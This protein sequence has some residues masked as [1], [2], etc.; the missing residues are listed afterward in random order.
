ML[1]M[2]ACSSS[3]D[4]DDAVTTDEVV[5]PDDSSSDDSSIS[6]EDSS[7]DSSSSESETTTTTFAKGADVSWLTEMEA[8]GKKF[9][10]SDG[11]ETECMALLQSLG[12]DAI[13]LRVWVDPTDGY[14][15]KEDVLT[16]AKRANA[17]GMRL[18]IDF[19]YSDSW[20]DPEKQ[21]KP[22]AWTNYSLS[23]LKTAITDHTKDVLNAL[24]DEG[25]TPEWVQVGN[26]IGSGIL[27]DT[28]ATVSG[29]TWNATYDGVTYK[30]NQSNFAAFISTGCAAVR[31]VCP[32]AKIVIHLQDA[33]G[34]SGDYM[35]TWI[36]GD[37][38]KTYGT[39]D[40]DV[41]GFSIYPETS[42]WSSKISTYISRMNSVISTYGKEVMVCETGMSW[43]SAS[44]CNSYLTSLLEKTSAIDG[45]L[46]VFYWEPEAYG[47]WNGY[48][49]GAF[50]NSGKPTEALDA[51]K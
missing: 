46:G 24:K 39:T 7:N 18:M 28:E 8:S 11:T 15:N 26:E 48:T 35:P 9:Y 25:I 38:L 3:D 6:D 45:C 40:Y 17:L 37:I 23:E 20:A 33:D 5:T 10:A 29:A 50:D 47:Q 34:D 36:C 27:W 2:A 14:C 16:K 4:D 31:A 42:G 44:T 22:S 19:H 1:T 49:K 30:T 21:I 12:M 43:D 51:F 32:D 41:V 13:R